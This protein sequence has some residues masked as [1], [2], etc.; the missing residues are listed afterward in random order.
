MD[1]ASEGTTIRLPA[2]TSSQTLRVTRPLVIDAQGAA[3]DGRGALEYAVVVSADDVELDGLTVVNVA[4]PVQDGAVHAWDVARF[5]F[6]GGEIRDAAGAC[7]SVARS[8]DSSIVD[9]V[10]A[11]CGQEG[12]HA[13]RADR[14]VVRGNRIEG[15]NPAGTYDPEWEAG[16]AKVTRSDGVV[17]ESN[18]VSHNRG[19][20][21]WCDIDCR[22][23]RVHDNRVWSNDRAGIQI[24]ISE[25]AQVTRNA[26]W[27]NGWA[28]TTWGWGAGILVSSSSRVEVDANV[29]AWNADG[30]VVVSQDRS[31]APN[32]I[33]GDRTKGN[34]VASE[35]GNEAFGLGW[36]LD[37]RGGLTDAAAGNGGASDRFWFAG[38]EGGDARFAWDRAFAGL[39]AF[40]ATPGGTGAS[41]VTDAEMASILEAAGIPG[42][43]SNARPAQPLRPRDLVGPGLLVLGVAVVAALFAGEAIRRR[44]RPTPPPAGPGPAA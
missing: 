17:F 26:V 20:G 2:C 39:D 28:F 19:P 12:I 21:I 25:G 8:P 30:I 41:Y 6:R 3:I 24:E 23:L 34:F 40:R 35:G 29:L 10:L 13:T 9:S 11:G 32:P 31:D 36:L 33:T 42:R 22:D 38:P 16:G 44:R 27:D 4:N 43:P 37:W 18:Q 15:N 14:L 7:I 5:T 1:A